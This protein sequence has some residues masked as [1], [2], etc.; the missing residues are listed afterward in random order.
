MA[1]TEILNI[2]LEAHDY[3]YRI[4]ALGILGLVT[5]TTIPVV[6]ALIDY[7][8]VVMVYDY[9]LSHTNEILAGGNPVQ[10]LVDAHMIPES[11]PSGQENETDIDFAGKTCEDVKV[12]KQQFEDEKSQSDAR[13]ELKYFD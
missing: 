1:K 7:P 4:I 10:D 9:C 3:L 6:N 12:L 5:L 11:V 13:E 2:K 8:E